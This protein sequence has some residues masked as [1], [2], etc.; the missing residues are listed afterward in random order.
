MR[1][2]A[3]RLVLAV[4]IIARSASF[5]GV[6]TTLALVNSSRAQD[7]TPTEVSEPVD[8]P[9]SPQ[10]DLQAGDE[11]GQVNGDLDAEQPPDTNLETGLP[12]RTLLTPL[13]W[14]HLS[15]LSLTAY[16]GYN[17]NPGFE[18]VPLGA[19]VTSVGGLVFYTS[20]FKG[21]QLGAQY[22]PFVWISSQQTLKDF[23]ATSV[24]LRSTRHINGTWHWSAGNHFRYLPTHSMAEGKGFVADPGG[25]FSFGNAFL[26]SGR[27]ILSNGIVG[28]LTDRYNEH[29]SLT[30]HANQTFTRLS[31][32]L[33]TL[34]TD[35]LPVQQA[36]QFSTGVTWRNQLSLRD[37]IGLK[38][39]YGIQTSTGT[40][41]ENVNSHTA[42]VLWTHQLKPNLD[43]S[44]SFGPAWSIYFGNQNSNTNSPGRA[45]LHGSLALAKQFH[46]GGVV[47]AFARS[48]SFSGVISNGFNNRYDLTAIRQFNARLNGSVTASYIQQ[49]ML[50]A[51]GAKGELASAEIRYFFSPNWAVFSQ[52]RYLHI[53]G[54]QPIL[55]PEKSVIVGFRWSWIPEKP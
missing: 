43:L 36:I 14:G 52:V 18:R 44:A 39:V 30:F 37:S 33:G 45:T 19:S 12:L 9:G 16:E 11:H 21:W 42:A 40:S 55:A 29:S 50:N 24:D 46:G 25:G 34:S 4:R 31:S 27:N 20:E 2:V 22:L 28:S 23:A 5:A 6:L 10:S 53:T 32:Y 7:S 51:R 41:V 3:T 35:T 47:A 1:T 54:D 17:S 26:S 48:N 13:H 49:E 8:Y 15:L 38:Y